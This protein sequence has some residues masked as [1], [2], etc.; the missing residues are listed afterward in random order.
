MKTHALEQEY[1]PHHEYLVCIDSDGCA[2]DTME[3]K[4]KEC[5][6]PAGI[7][8]FDLQPVSSLAR[9]T[10]EFVNLYSK[11]RGTNRFNALLR[12]LDLLRERPEA[13]Q[14]GYRPFD[15]E[16][17]RHWVETAPLLNND[18]VAALAE[19]EPVM[20]RIIDWS[21]DVNRRIA[22]MVHGIPPFPFVRE[23][24]EKIS[25]TADIVIVSAT[26]RE[27][28]VKEWTEHGIDRYVNVLG[29][30][31]DGSKAE[32]IA[33]V[34]GTYA[35]DHV[36]MMGDAP[37]DHKAA[38]KNGVLFYPIRPLDEVASWEEF[39]REDADRF[40]AGTYAGDVMRDRHAR[41]DAC[42]PEEPPWKK[43]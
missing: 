35:P 23:S 39:F 24:L 2:F 25:K 14:R 29:A 19:T 33:A 11:T 42:L 3:I 40:L 41:F 10:W 21:L 16:V 43:A 31:E 26:P 18:A 1:V 9:E 37:G 15:Y 7:E 27:A 12:V 6:I 38:D 32:I 34:K 5:F 30:Q 17:F 28:L 20:K 8:H 22:H 13:V 36:L 4:Q